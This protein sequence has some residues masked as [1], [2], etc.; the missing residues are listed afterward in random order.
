MKALIYNTWDY[1]GVAMHEFTIVETTNPKTGNPLYRMTREG[2]EWT[3]TYRGT[4]VMEVE[5]T[6]NGYKFSNA[7]KK[8][9]G[10]DAASE[11]YIMYKFLDLLGKHRREGG[12]IYDGVIE[13][14]KDSKSITI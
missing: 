3:D 2:S 4:T 5:D 9:V 6:G 8:E 14:I 10:Y 11:M 7:T 12:G 1:N 13:I